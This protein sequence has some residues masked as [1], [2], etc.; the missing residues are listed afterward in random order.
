ME[1]SHFY[2]FV[3]R[4]ILPLFTGSFIAGETESS[5][6][7][8]EVALG[9]GNSVLLKPSKA[10]EYRLILKRGQPFKSFEVSLIKTILEE[11]AILS[12][13]GLENT[14]YLQKLQ[15]TIIEK[16][17]I[18]SI[19]T[20]SAS[21][22]IIG[23]ISC[24]ERW[25]TR[26]YEGENVSMGVFVNL[27]A[28]ADDAS[29]N[30]ADIMDS[31]FFVRIT[32]GVSSFVEFDKKGGLI[33]YINL[34]N[35]K[36]APT[37]SPYIFDRVARSCNDKRVGIILTA[38]GD[39]LIFYARQ[40]MF[41]K[42]NGKWCVYSH[43]EIIRLLYTNVSYTA[44]QIRRAIYS[45]ALDCSFGYMGACIIYLNKDKTHEAL[46]QINIADIVSESHFE[47]KKLMELGENSKLY[48]LTNPPPFDENITFEEY[49]TKFNCTKARAIKN[50]IAGKKLYELDRKLLE[51][52]V[53]IDGATVIDFDGTIIAV[54]AILKI[55]A[56]SLGGGR[57]AA[58]KSM[59]KY[60]VGIKVSQD[61]IMQGFSA[62]KHGKVKLIFDVG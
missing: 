55:E 41:A 50:I 23:V 40:L 35:P 59:A 25:A 45:T 39:I 48:N 28:L 58:T 3:D 26:T 4:M 2:G 34:K 10:D 47:E 57:L 61:G 18:D 7:D 42:R 53:G 6:R 46:K 19:T 62:D 22:T 51:N 56:G 16:A 21:Q 8:L 20:D 29:V 33:G 1:K 44:K 30:F 24:L 15:N 13:A 12:E 11:I 54:G 36:H 43:D 38:R 49:L 27:S 60:G 52:L 32:D 37:V 17:L 9:K 14:V 31:D 5:S